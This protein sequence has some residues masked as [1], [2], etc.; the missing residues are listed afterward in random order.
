M[1]RQW[2]GG[3]YKLT[4]QPIRILVMFDLNE[5]PVRFNSG[6]QHNH[7][8]IETPMNNYKYIWKPL[9]GLDCGFDLCGDYVLSVLICLA[10]FS[11]CLK[12]KIKNAGTYSQCFVQNA[13]LTKGGRCGL[14]YVQHVG[15]AS[16]YQPTSSTAFTTKTINRFPKYRYNSSQLIQT[17]YEGRFC[18]YL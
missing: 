6:I 17:N 3:D 7:C 8:G 11:Q 2:R 14:P 9:C 4:H 13:F 15:S 18:V 5:I 12:W 16:V 10:L 1:L